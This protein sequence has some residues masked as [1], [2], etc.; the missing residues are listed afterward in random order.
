MATQKLTL[1]LGLGGLSKVTGG[2]RS[3]GAVAQSTL[4]GLSRYALPAAGLVATA[5]GLRSV[6]GGLSEII[7]QG[8]KLEDTAAATSASLSRL[9]RFQQLFIEGGRAGEDVTRTFGR[10][11]QAVF[12]AATRGGPTA[13][14]ISQLGLDLDHLTSMRPE[15]QFEA[16]G[17]AIGGIEHPTYRAG[18][19]MQI[20]GSTG[21]ELLPVFAA[22]SNPARTDGALGRLPELLERNA[23]VL[24]SI[25]DGFDHAKLKGQQFWIGVLD[26]IGPAI[27]QVGRAIAGID[28]TEAGQ[29]VGAF[30]TLVGDTWRDGRFA[31]L[32]GLTIEAGF[33][34][35]VR[36]VGRIMTEFTSR[37]GVGMAATIGNSI[38][39]VF[40]ESWKVMGEMF[41]RWTG[42]LDAVATYAA[43][44]LILAFA[45]AFNV[46]LD[47]LQQKWS[48]V[49]KM[50]GIN[51]PPVPRM[52]ERA[53]SFD[54]SMDAG[55]ERGEARLQR[56][57][58]LIES[59]KSGVRDGLDLA[60]PT[61]TQLSATDRLKGLLDEII[62]QRERAAA[63]ERGV[64]DAMRNQV[65][66][67]NAMAELR[68][69]EAEGLARV[70]EF[71]RQRALVDGDFRVNDAAKFTLKLDLLRQ[72]RAELAK[73]IQLLQ[74]R[75]A[76]EGLSEGERDQI[77]QRMDQAQARLGGIDVEMANM[78]PDPY[79]PGEQME[80]AMTGL[81]NQFGTTAQ[82]IGRTFTQVIGT[83]VDS[84]SGGLQKLIG[85][86]EY[87]SSRLGSIAGPVMGA[88]TAAISRMFTEWIVRRAIAGVR[89]ILWSQKEG[90]ADTAAKAPGALM[91]SISSYG[92]AAAIG[93]AAVVAA[94]AA[95]GGF[96]EGGFTGN[97]PTNQIAGV[98]HGGEYVFD[99]A[100]VQRLGIPALESLRSGD[101]A[102]RG[103]P[104]GAPASSTHINIAAMSDRSEAR[105]WAESTEGE[106]WF[107]DMSRRTAHRM[108]RT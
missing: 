12:N 101:I 56:W 97:I 74:E 54:A 94:M 4:G 52:T 33:E 38:T 98:V 105:K 45:K 3:V 31:E 15:E 58:Q 108:N 59:M 16:I 40:F 90:A 69:K 86:T 87:W 104:S 19:A 78:G 37:I 44:S 100:S 13:E 48:G 42:V 66:I 103:E 25:G 34:I 21:T 28:L 32:I 41:I 96:R 107:L 62:A 70:A 76:M 14:A 85:D 88:L 9:V 7:N 65:P 43:D 5:F 29:K 84:V 68:H 26:Q 22:I 91:A 35:G 73:V 67:A 39:T 27:D 47:F 79:S 20:F 18:L 46:Q 89:N 92:V 11:E 51:L 8:G 75:M 83:A 2:L 81:E 53:P 99:A 93:L 50:M 77:G 49:A 95:F 60:A 64:T 82:A 17:K 106:A 72:E 63:A 6:A 80:A 61:E 10:M 30:V 23:A 1:Q 57:N 36:A 71:Q 24:G 102:T 55:W